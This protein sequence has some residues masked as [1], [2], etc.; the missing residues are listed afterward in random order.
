MMKACSMVLEL[1]LFFKATTITESNIEKLS[2]IAQSTIEHVNRLHDLKNALLGI[3]KTF[4]G[5]KIHALEHLVQQ[6]RSDGV[7]YCTDTNCFE[8][9]HKT[10]AV[11][12]FAHSSKRNISLQ[13]EMIDN[14]VEKKITNLLNTRIEALDVHAFDSNSLL[15]ET[16]RHQGNIK[17]DS[18]FLNIQL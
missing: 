17:I 7:S 6:L 3:K 1:C 13:Q 16:Y 8:E 9:Q 18:G 2:N 14:I 11:E 10:S 5:L 12:N 4:N 15:K